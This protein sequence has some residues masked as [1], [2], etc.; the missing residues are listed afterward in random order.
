MQGIVS[1]LFGEEAVLYKEKINFKLPSGE[2]FKP[3][4]DVLV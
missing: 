3:H 2:E 1:Q 4:Q